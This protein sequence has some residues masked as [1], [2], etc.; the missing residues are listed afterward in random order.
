MT[1]FVK[2]AILTALLCAPA[3]SVAHVPA[4][5]S[6]FLETWNERTKATTELMNVEL[7]K[8]K[9]E[10]RIINAGQDTAAIEEAVHDA[11]IQTRI[12]DIAQRQAFMVLWECVLDG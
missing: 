2:P 4:N 3:P 10:L 6:A 1:A 5:C 7:A 12:A 9:E 11:E 8:K